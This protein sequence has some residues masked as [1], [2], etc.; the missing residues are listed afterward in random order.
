MTF[1]NQDLKNKAVVAA[2]KVVDNSQ[3]QAKVNAQAVLDDTNA[4]TITG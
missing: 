4:A 3:G 1:Q 2:Q